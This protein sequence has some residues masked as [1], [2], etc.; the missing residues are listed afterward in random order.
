MQNLGGGRTLLLNALPLSFL[1]IDLPIRT[2]ENPRIGRHLGAFAEWQ[3]V[4]DPATRNRESMMTRWQ[5][6]S[7]Q[8]PASSRE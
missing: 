2:C 7:L 4:L 8:V 1:F 6:R 3:G 5:N